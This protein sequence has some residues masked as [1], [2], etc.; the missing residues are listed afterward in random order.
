MK[1]YFIDALTYAKA[2][3]LT[4][5]TSVQLSKETETTSDLQ[6]ILMW[7]FMFSMSNWEMT[8]IQREK[9]GKNLS[10]QRETFEKNSN[11]QRDAEKN[12]SQQTVTIRKNLSQL[13]K[14]SEKNL[15]KSKI[16][17]KNLSWQRV[18]VGKNSNQQRETV[19]KN[20]S[21]QFQEFNLK[22]SD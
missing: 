9:A 17:E 4:E 3:V 2:Q 21:Q 16:T 8:N 22:K 1:T 19:R 5:R 11:K 6:M 18:M 20:L 14:K 10:Q 15:N 7:F 12:L 13:R